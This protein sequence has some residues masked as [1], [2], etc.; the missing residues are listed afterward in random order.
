MIV[1][2]VLGLTWVVLY[3]VAASSIGFMDSLGAWNVAI[4]F[5]FMFG[6][7]MVATRWK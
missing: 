5:A 4:G 3:Y 7:L 2:L 1:L 6:G